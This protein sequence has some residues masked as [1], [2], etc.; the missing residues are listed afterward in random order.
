MISYTVI[1]ISM[2]YLLKE[3]LMTSYIL[4]LQSRCQHD[5]LP[6]PSVER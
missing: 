4:H 2:F 3:M 5:N 1:E 6:K